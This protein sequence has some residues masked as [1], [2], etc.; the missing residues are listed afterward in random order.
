VLLS[1]SHRF[2]FIKTVKTASTSVEC[3]L[4]PYCC[5]PGHVVQHW[6]PTLISDYG[7][8]GERWP[9]GDIDNQ[10]FYNHMPA[11]LIRELC[12]EFDRYTRI[13]TVRHP[14]DRA[15]SMFHYSHSAWQPAGGITI[16]FAK[17]LYH[18]GQ[19][20]ELQ[21]LFYSFVLHSYFDDD[22]LLT[23]NGDLAI[24]RWVRYEHLVSDLNLLSSQLG[25]SNSDDLQQHLPRF[26]AN[27][28]GRSDVPPIY[29]YLSP[30]AITLINERCSWTFNHFG[31]IQTSL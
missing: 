31:Y 1:R 17:H 20:S 11:S 9:K 10:G 7:I 16:D 25:L 24:D 4:E 12:P 8:V 26:K 22:H 30:D 23:V 13:T 19:L 15:V 28:H 27:R 2:I 6:T 21:S 29:A 14:Y 5:P 18:T 3:F